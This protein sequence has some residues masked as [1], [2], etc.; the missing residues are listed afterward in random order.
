[1]KWPPNNKLNFCNDIS[2]QEQKLI[3]LQEDKSRLEERL[4]DVLDRLKTARNTTNVE[5]AYRQE[6]R[7]NAKLAEIYKGNFF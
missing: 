1:M 3:G 4:E 7:A 2:F 6:I 5:E